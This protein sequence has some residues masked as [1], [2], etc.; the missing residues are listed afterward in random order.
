VNFHENSRDVGTP[1]V[2]GISA[3]VGV[4]AYAITVAGSLLQHPCYC[5]FPLCCL[6]DLMFLLSLM[7]LEC[8]NA[9]VGSSAVS[10]IPLISDVPLMH[11][12]PSRPFSSS[13]I[14]QHEL[15]TITNS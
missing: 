3:A 12:T 5:G 2:S 9:V 4:L 15:T 7:L 6:F 8:L 1:T 10:G 13:D 14:H 11:A